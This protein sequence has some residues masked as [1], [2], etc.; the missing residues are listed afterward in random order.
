MNYK[1]LLIICILALMI[2]PAVTFSQNGTEKTTTYSLD[3]VFSGGGGLYYLR[4]LGDE[5][6]WYGEEDAVAPGWSN[7]AHGVI[8][9]NTI[10]VLWA[11]VPKGFIMQSGNLVIQINSDDELVLLEQTG[12]F[13]GT[14]LWTRT[15]TGVEGNIETAVNGFYLS[16]NYPNPFNPNT[17]ISWQ[18]AVGSNVELKIYDILGNEITTLIDEFKSP[19]EYKINFDASS[20]SAGVYYYRLITSASQTTRKMVLL[21]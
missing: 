14:D 15:T 11:D 7:V 3:G 9:G 19:G 6:L 8:S 10:T 5:L 20:L 16:Q 18:M 1:N 4:Q 2:I 17:V 21:K 13:F 12:E